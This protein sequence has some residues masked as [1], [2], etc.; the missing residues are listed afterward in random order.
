MYSTDFEKLGP[1]SLES[2][3]WKFF[4]IKSKSK[5]NDFERR[6]PFTSLEKLYLG[7]RTPL[8]QEMI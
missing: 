7:C 3:S 2:S 8:S 1:Y 5:N 6:H 4:T